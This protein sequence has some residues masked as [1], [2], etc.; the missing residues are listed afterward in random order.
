MAI[1][2]IALD[3]DG[4]LLTSDKRITPA[5][6]RALESCIERGVRIVIATGRNIADI[7]KE[8][9]EISGLRYVIAING[10]MVADLE[11][12]EMLLRRSIFW[13]DALQII[14]ML[15]SYPAMYDAY[16]EGLG[17]TEL[18]FCETLD[19]YI[20][21]L[22]T[23]SLVRRSRDGIPDMYEYIAKHQSIV[24]KI[25]VTFKDEQTKE[26]VRGQ[27]LNMKQIVITSSVPN[28]LELNFHEATKGSGLSF[29]TNYLHLKKE[30]TMACGDE[31]NDLAMLKQ[32]GIGVAMGNGADFVKQQADFVTTSNDEDG[33]AAVIQRFVL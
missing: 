17:K 7:P 2:L 28:N 11:T 19:Q 10:A 16:I 22:T 8:I 31:G 29:L 15:R 21:N 18:R 32:A 5:T 3:L 9:K 23:R 25:N 20:P 33:V 30:E 12:G 27:L 24:D 26:Q 13:K 1:R 4:T 6:K 14:D